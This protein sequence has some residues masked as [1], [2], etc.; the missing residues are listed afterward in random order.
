[1]SSYEGTKIL[2]SQNG[3]FVGIFPNMEAAMLHARQHK[4]PMHTL[5]V[6]EVPYYR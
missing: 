6:E 2:L 1:M 3:D 4:L 5:K